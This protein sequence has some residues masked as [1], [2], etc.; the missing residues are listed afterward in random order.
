MDCCRHSFY[1]CMGNSRISVGSFV[2]VSLSLRSIS[3]DT[4]EHLP[5]ANTLHLI[6]MFR[7]TRIIHSFSIGFVTTSS[8]NWIPWDIRCISCRDL[9]PG[10]PN[11]DAILKCFQKSK[12]FLFV[13]DEEFFS[14]KNTSIWWK[15]EW[16][17]PWHI[18][19]IY[20]ENLRNTALVNY[21]QIRSKYID[22]HQIQAFIWL[23]KISSIFVR[24]GVWGNMWTSDSILS[25]VS[26]WL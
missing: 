3:S 5:A 23:I 10:F 8:L 7:L 6:F 15:Q 9:A 25:S 20:F 2:A 16:R 21:D 26:D 11:S 19:G 17:I 12:K 13:E 22:H 4:T 14:L 24:R 18:F 1:I